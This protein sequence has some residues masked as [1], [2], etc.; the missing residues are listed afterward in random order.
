MQKTAKHEIDLTTGPLF[1]K[2]LIV[3]VPLIL[4]NILQLLFNAADVAVVGIF[5]GDDAVAAVGANTALINL[6]INLFVGL[7]A[8]ASVVLAKYVGQGNKERAEKLV[9]TA[10]LLSVIIGVGLSF[11]GVFGAKTF[12]TWMNCDPLILDQAALYL[13]IYFIGMPIIMLYNFA[14]G[15]LRAVGDTLR[16]MLFL[17]LG[18]FINVG[19]NVFFVTVCNMSVDG[20]A[21][22]TITS[23]AVSAVL[24]LVIMFKSEGYSKLSLKR[25]RIYKSEFIEILKVGLPSGIQASMFS[26]SNVLIQSTVNTFLKVG[27][28]ANA[29]AHQFDA[30]VAMTGNGVALASMSVV[31]QNYGAKNVG[32]IKRAIMLA[33]ATVLVADT[34]VGGIIL[35]LAEPLCR[36]M[37]EDAAVIELAITRMTIMCLT[38]CIGGVMDVLTYSLRALGKSTT[39]MVISILFVCVFRIVWLNTFYLLNPTFAMIY[40]SYPISWLMSIIVDVIFL[41]PT[42]RKIKG[43][44]NKA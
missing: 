21:I 17:L 41:I 28:T 14:A 2:L 24:A 10:I 22:A 4:T 35:L 6:I 31:S 7:G 38:F 44:V 5:K 13:R 30:F 15:V 34:F 1:K 39:A 18:G 33:V 27:T 43:Q 26:I 23:Q 16:P 11:V 40:Y 25:L 12:L 19:L 29:V 42:I 9:G 32:R 3:A 37:T 8:G 36:I 20:V